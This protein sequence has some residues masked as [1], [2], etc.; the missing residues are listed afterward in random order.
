M[1]RNFTI[2]TSVSKRRTVHV[3]FVS[4]R[5]FS[6]VG[7]KFERITIPC[8]LG[9]KLSESELNIRILASLH[10]EFLRLYLSYSSSLPSSMT[11]LPVDFEAS[12]LAPS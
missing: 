9:I 8:S 5:T 6:M 11:S 4:S 10:K 1:P 12:G 2:L 7:S 3:S